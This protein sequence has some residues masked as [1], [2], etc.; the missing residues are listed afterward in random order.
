MHILQQVAERKI[1]EAIERGEFDNLE[2]RGKPL[3]LE[4][5]SGIPEDLRLAYKI[6]KNANCL[7]PEIEIKRDIRQMED[8]L[9][10]LEDEQEK[11]RQLKRLNWA[12]T[13]L[14]MLRDRPVNFEEHERYHARIAEKLASGRPGYSSIKP[15]TKPS[16][17]PPASSTASPTKSGESPLR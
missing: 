4:D 17:H 11:Y 16:G 5:D 15:S 2:G 1:R 8:L 14:N 13:K 6:L 3:V 12:V 9:A 7:P 10:A